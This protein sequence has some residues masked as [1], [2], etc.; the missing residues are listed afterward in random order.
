MSGRRL[1][2]CCEQYHPSVGGVQEVMRQIAERLAARGFDVCV[3]TGSHPQRS[4]DTSLNGV[5]IVSFPITGNRVGG[6]HGPI[7]EYHRFLKESAFD[8]I[9]VKAAQQWTFDA[10]IDVLDQLDARKVFIPCGFSRLKDPKYRVYYKDMPGWL[11]QFDEL[12]FYASN[13]QD[14]KFARDHG[15]SH[16]RL[17]SNGVDE[18]EFSVLPERGMRERLGIPNENLLLLSVGSRIVEKGHWEVLEAF[19][20]AKLDRPSTLVINA[21]PVGQNVIGQIRRLAKLLLSARLPLSLQKLLIQGDSRKQV[22]L[23]NLARPELIRLYFEADLFVFASHVEYSPLV[24]FEASAAGLPFIS[25]AA[26]NSAEIAEWIGNGRIIGAK[27]GRG[28]EVSPYTLADAIEEAFRDP[29][30]LKCV[31]AAGRTKVFEQ[32]VTWSRILDH[33]IKALTG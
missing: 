1:L 16:I 14:I 19:R 27:N 2:L 33:Y 20:R 13:Y 3:A 30:A 23:T 18:R 11:S 22:L 25:S 32:G 4:K 10:M 7:S 21:S 26:G 5:R 29:V 24:L 12:I 28:A 9:L 15:L 31:G 17:I 8:A 6:L